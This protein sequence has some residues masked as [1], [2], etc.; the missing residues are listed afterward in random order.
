MMQAYDISNWF[1]I[2]IDVLHYSRQLVQVALT[3]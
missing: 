1:G 3:Y 2:G